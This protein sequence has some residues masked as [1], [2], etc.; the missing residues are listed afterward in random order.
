MSEKKSWDIQPRKSTRMDIPR[1]VQPP[2]ERPAPA[3]PARQPAKQVAPRPASHR[4]ETSMNKKKRKPEA[5]QGREREPLK[6]RRRR[7][8][9]RSMLLY[10][11][12]GILILAAIVGFFWIPVFRIKTVY[13]AGPDADGMQL[14]ATNALVGRENVVFPRNSLFLFPEGTIR[15]QI[16]KHYPE[17]SAISISRSL[18]GSVSITSIP[19]EQAFVWCGETY[20]PAPAAPA[21]TPA[22]S[23]A[24]STTSS[25]LPTA[26][27]STDSLGVIFAPVSS[28]AISRTDVLSLYSPLEST[29]N[30]T[31]TLGAVIAQARSLPNVLQFVKILR[32]MGASIVKVVIHGDEVDFY[33]QNNT[34]ITYVLGREEM[35]RQLAQSAFP[36]LNV[37]DGSLEYIDLRFDGKVYFKRIGSAAQAHSVTANTLTASSTRAH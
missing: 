27:Y 33:T 21:I 4:G 18:F 5:S 24:T 26:C 14:I 13:A 2:F 19:R 28:D 34:R 1:A 30:A 20:M 31:D 37:G 32:A 3:A 15:A 29:S 22:I 23:T 6:D 7:E 16:L 8:R 36:A 10:T 17:I 9:R 12:L 25:S 11:V 35:A